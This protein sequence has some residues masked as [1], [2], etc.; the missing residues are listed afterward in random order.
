MKFLSDN[1]KKTLPKK[2]ILNCLDK[3]DISFKELLAKVLSA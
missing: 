2:K 1:K 3:A